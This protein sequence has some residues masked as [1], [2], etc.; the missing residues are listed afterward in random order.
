MIEKIKKIFFKDVTFVFITKILA[1]FLATISAVIIGRNIGASIYGEYSYTIAILSILS[2]FT[3]FGFDNSMLFLINKYKLRSKK[4]LDQL[5]TAGLIISVVI[6]ALCVALLNTDIIKLIAKPQYIMMLKIISPILILMTLNKL[7][8]TYMRILSGVRSSVLINDIGYP[9]L[10]LLIIIFGIYFWDPRKTLIVSFYLST[11]FTSIVYVYYGKSASFNFAIPQKDV[12]KELTQ[13]SL[14]LL[15][16]SALVIILARLDII[17]VGKMID[18]RSVGIYNMVFQVAVLL[19]FVNNSVTVVYV[20]VISQ[21][22]VE[23]KLDEL[24]KKFK[25]ISYLV[26]FITLY[27]F[28]FTVIFSKEILSIFGDEFVA[29]SMVLIILSIGQLINNFSC[30]AGYMNSMTGH[31]EYALYDSI[32]ALV[33][34]SVLNYTLIPIYG[35]NGA[36]FATAVT[37]LFRSVFHQFMVWRNLSVTCVTSKYV[38]GT[39]LTSII[40]LMLYFSKGIINIDIMI[41]KIVVYGLLYTV[42]FAGLSLVFKMIDFHE[43]LN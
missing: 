8:F 12:L 15:L 39:L 33:M 5:L 25:N 28:G 9:V 32:I 41:V 35:I 19:S 40:T 21:L 11:I 3:I 30:L 16:T 43:G 14:P 26:Y 31:P 18:E 7:L 6:S 23:K 42:V 37:I 29:G 13:Y 2:V 38:K 4:E 10:K 17:F 22:F 20:P 36:A 1:Q 27:L 34:N 24:R